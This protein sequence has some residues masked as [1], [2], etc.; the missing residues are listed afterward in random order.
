MRLSWHPLV[1]GI[2][3][4]KAMADSGDHPSS[5]PHESHT[6]SSFSQFFLSGAPPGASA[7]M[8]R[9]AEAAQNEDKK[10]GPLRLASAQSLLPWFKDRAQD[11]SYPMPWGCKAPDPRET[12]LDDLLKTITPSILMC[13]LRHRT[14]TCCWTLADPRPAAS[15]YLQPAPCSQGLSWQAAGCSH[16]QA[17]AKNKTKQ[18]SMPP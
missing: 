14:L 16:T 7:L 2:Y 1:C 9:Q 18:K 8:G 4:A 6:W 12:E 11:M 15:L 10:P 13:G 5:L 17:T 3:H